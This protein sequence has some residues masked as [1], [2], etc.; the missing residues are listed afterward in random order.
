MS[1]WWSPAVF[2]FAVA[3]GW[4]GA[5]APPASAQVPAEPSPAPTYDAT[6]RA[7]VVPS[8]KAVHVEL[9]VVQPQQ[10]NAFVIEINFRIDPA[11][12]TRFRGD[13]EVVVEGDS[14]VWKVPRQGGKLRWVF[15]IEHLRNDRAYDARSAS[16]FALFRGDDLVP[17]A[18]VR[19]E[20]M[21]ESKTRLVLRTPKGWTAVAPFPEDSDGSYIVDRLERR[22]DRPTGWIMVGKLLFVRAPIAGC[23]VTFAAPVGQQ[24]RR[25]D[26]LA[27]LRWT[28]PVLRDLL[29]ELPAELLIVGAGDPMFRGGLAGP[30]SVFLH[31]DRPLIDKDGTSPLLHEIMHVVTN[32]R[33]GAE[34]DWIVEGLA[35]LYSIELL[36]RSRTMSK[37]RKEISYKRLAKKGKKAGR[38]GVA[39]SSGAVTARA[40]VVLRALDTEI[41][42]RSAGKA[43]LD[44]VVVALSRANIE[45]T[46]EGFQ[47]IA[48]SST[49]VDLAPFFKALA[50]E[51]ARR[52]A[53]TKKKKTSRR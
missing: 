7:R 33:A 44:D 13:G 39:E 47:Q 2:G 16:N 36:A 32:A 5:V 28:L 35:E 24:V 31:A 20:G 45:L 53:K 40:V 12:Q 4:S 43:S 18:R 48:Q 51:E 14:A 27:L 34:A 6:Y 9:E 25:F 26:Q 46:V 17:T 49:G 8:E 3:L 38:L 29:G 15:L 50:Q 10:P 42:E 37:S 11:R 19:T 1:R 52:P 21:A 23:R 30:D 41:R 22:F